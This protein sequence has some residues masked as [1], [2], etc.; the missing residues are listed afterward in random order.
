MISIKTTPK[1]NGITIQG[2]YSDLNNLYDA[3]SEYTNFYVDGI[4]HEI[5][6]DYVKK[7]GI[8]VADMDPN[9]KDE[10]FTLN[11]DEITYFEE[12]REN[13]L[14]LC[15]DI[16]HAYQGDRGVCLVENGRNLFSESNEDLPSSNLQFSVE[17]LYPWAFY[18]LFCLQ[19]ILDNMY[20]PEWLN[21]TDEFRSSYTELDIQLYRAVLSTFVSLMWKNLQELFGKDFETL[22]T[23]FINKDGSGL[24]DRTYLTGICN[25]LVADNCEGLSKAK[26]TNFKKDILLVLAYDSMDSDILFDSD[27]SK[28]AYV[29][30][31]KKQYNKALEYINKNATLPYVTNRDFLSE[32]L[33][34]A[35]ANKEENAEEWITKIFGNADWDN[36]EW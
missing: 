5:E 24:L 15:Y 23:Y 36:L 16:R 11:Q 32:I 34:L 22:Y 9:Q 18:Y 27:F 4:M 29:I 10:F 30:A 28:E 20:K 19:D 12:L 2:D 6:A 35:I 8:A 1:L 3:L 33:K 7:H 17:V 13:V 21:S 26:Y 25:Y 14:G 31:S